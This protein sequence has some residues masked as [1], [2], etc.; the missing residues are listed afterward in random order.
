MSQYIPTEELIGM[1]KGRNLS[2]EDIT[3]ITD[4]IRPWRSYPSETLPKGC[5]VEVKLSKEV[6]GTDKHPAKIVSDGIIIV[7]G[8]F[9][10]DLGA[11][12]VAWRNF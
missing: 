2:P 8:H 9:L 5:V 11:E 6:L 4:A 3:A 12:I 7:A 1:L 10:F